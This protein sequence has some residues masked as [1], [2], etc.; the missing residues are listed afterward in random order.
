MR[1]KL[2]KLS[3]EKLIDALLDLAT[4]S[5]RAADMLERLVSS[6]A[7]NLSRFEQKMDDL[8]SQSRFYDWRHTSSFAYELRYALEDLK[9]ANPNRLKECGR[10]LL[11][12]KPMRPFSMP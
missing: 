10:S 9:S 4:D 3:K 8:K 7:E 6:P 11:F 12:M 1:D 2:L 5:D